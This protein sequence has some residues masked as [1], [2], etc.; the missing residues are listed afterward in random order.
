ML[1]KSQGRLSIVVSKGL[2]VEN[3]Q[4][5]LSLKDVKNHRWLRVDPLT[6][7]H[8]IRLIALC[9]ILDSELDTRTLSTL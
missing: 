3:I 8:I 2:K 5:T 9:R 4:N 7:H 1:M 6:H